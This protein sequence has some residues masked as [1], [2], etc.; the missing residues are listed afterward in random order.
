[1]VVSNFFMLDKDEREN[2]FEKSFLLADINPDIIFGIFFL[3]MSNADINFQ[4]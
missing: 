1:M 2:F 3:T 4:A